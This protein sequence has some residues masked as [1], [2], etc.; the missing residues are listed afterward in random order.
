VQNTMFVI[1]LRV[2]TQ[3]SVSSLGFADQVFMEDCAVIERLKSTLALYFGEVQGVPTT[4]QE[5]RLRIACGLLSL[6]CAMRVTD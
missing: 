1:S 6:R 5:H 3:T 4:H 2:D